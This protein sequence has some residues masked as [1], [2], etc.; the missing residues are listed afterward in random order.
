MP[1]PYPREFRDEVVAVARERESTLEQGALD[2]GISELC[3][4]NWLTQ[5]DVE[6][7]A[8]PGVTVA[9]VE[10]A[11]GQGPEAAST[12]TGATHSGWCCDAAHASIISVTCGKSDSG[13]KDRWRISA[14]IVVTVSPVMSR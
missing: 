12:E 10:Q 4:A 8:C 11:R 9:E 2:F 14:A 1:M 7:G 5:A 13:G 6:D 3:L